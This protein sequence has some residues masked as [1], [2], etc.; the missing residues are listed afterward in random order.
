MSKEIELILAYFAFNNGSILID[1]LK[2]KKILRVLE[3]DKSESLLT[4]G[5]VEGEMKKYTI[6]NKGRN[7]MCAIFKIVGR[8]R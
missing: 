7:K 5:D 4:V 1:S 3:V 6:E 8:V 2:N